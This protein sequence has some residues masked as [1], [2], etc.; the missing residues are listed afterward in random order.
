MLGTATRLP[1]R[2]ARPCLSALTRKS[3]ARFGSGSPTDPPFGRA[4]S[5]TPSQRAPLAAVRGAPHLSKSSCSPSELPELFAVG[6][7]LV[8]EA[9][10]VADV[11]L[12]GEVVQV[13]PGVL[14]AGASPVEPEITLPDELAVV[15]PDVEVA[16]PDDRTI[17]ESKHRI[18]PFCKS[19]AGVEIGTLGC[20]W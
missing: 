18:S 2:F 5:A 8:G 11:D 17:V 1:S 4:V 15:A 20:D 6:A 3:L 12:I 19:V 7:V 10:V 13:V 16:L 9:A 14:R